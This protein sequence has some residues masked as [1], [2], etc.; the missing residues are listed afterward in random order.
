MAGKTTIHF[1][2]RPM[3]IDDVPVMSLWFEQ[4]ADLSLFDSQ[5]SLPVSRQSVEK[6]WEKTLAAGLPRGSYWFGVEDEQGELAGIA[7]LEGIN[8][9]NGDCVFPIFLAT[10]VRRIGLGIQVAAMLLDMAFSQLRLNRV[11][12]F[13]RSDNQATKKLVRSLGFTKEG[14]MRNA[15]FVGG[16]YYDQI[17]VGLLAEE[18][19]ARRAA[20]I[21]RTGRELQLR[22]GCATPETNPW[23]EQ[24][25]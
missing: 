22:L 12:T 18:W 1:C 24:Q 25:M 19:P 7:G 4:A 10:H 3:T 17:V 20:L 2:M 23:P 13:Y 21:E 5:S 11:T 8:Y 15:R 16:Q 14:S 9:V 6:D